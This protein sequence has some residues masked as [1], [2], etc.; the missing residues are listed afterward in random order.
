MK[1]KDYLKDKIIYISLLV[2]A[3]ITIEILL[4]P[5]DIHVFIRIYTALIIII[6]FLIGFLLEYYSKKK[7]YETIKSRIEELEEKYLVMEVLPK[8]NFTEA[9]ILENIIKDTGKSMIENVNKYKYMQEDYKDFIELWIH[10]IKIPIATSKMIIENNKNE[11]TESI[12]EEMDKIDNYTEQALFYARSNTVEKDYIIRKNALKEIVNA[13][14]LKN[15]NQLIQNNISINI[16]TLNQIVYTDSKWCIFI[17][18]QII[19]NSIKY[20]KNENKQVEIF[21]EEKKENIILHI[22]DNGIGIKESEISRVFEKGFTGENGRITGKKSTGI[23]LYL[24]K[25]L[26][27]KLCIGIELNSEKNIGTEVRLIFPKNSFTNI[28]D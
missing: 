25:K 22:R 28:T 11:I 20:T 15:K 9:T 4:I 26:C 12:N 5:Y 1:F 24:C 2:F 17:I 14:I 18:S 21:G 27:E 3:I 13:S 23:G 16:K 19:Q 6:A 7:F 10:E 8:T